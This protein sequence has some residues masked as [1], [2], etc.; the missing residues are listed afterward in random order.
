MSSS[1]KSFGFV[2]YFLVQIVTGFFG[3]GTG[4]IIL[5]ILMIFFGMTIIEANATNTI[6]WFVLAASSLTIFAMNGIIDYKIGTALLAGMAIGGYIGA[7]VALQKGD[8]WVKQLFALLVIA[9]AIKVL[10]F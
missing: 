8:A 2:L 5:Y 7:H 9:I 10:F 4:V 6:P 3:G 1:K